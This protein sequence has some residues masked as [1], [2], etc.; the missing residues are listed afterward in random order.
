[1]KEKIKCV[2]TAVKTAQHFTP[3]ETVKMLSRNCQHWKMFHGEEKAQ[4][5]LQ[6]QFILFLMEQRTSM[7]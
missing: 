1:M 4:I 3:K 5:S 2:L 7:E 6:Y